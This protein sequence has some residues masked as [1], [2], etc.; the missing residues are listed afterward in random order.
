MMPRLTMAYVQDVPAK[1]LWAL[2]GQ[3]LQDGLLEAVESAVSVSVFNRL[4]LDF[5]MY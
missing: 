4:V 5:D 1:V 2:E 3:C